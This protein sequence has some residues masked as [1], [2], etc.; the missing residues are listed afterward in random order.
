VVL[1]KIAYFYVHHHF[2]NDMF[3]ASLKS[4]RKLM[5]SSICAAITFLLLKQLAQILYINEMNHKSD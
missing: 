5:E 2:R 3:F 1:I 4:L